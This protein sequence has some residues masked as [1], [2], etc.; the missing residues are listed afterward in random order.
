ME[1]GIYGY[2]RSS[3]K[4]DVSGTTLPSK[5]ISLPS[6]K[7]QLN[8]PTGKAGQTPIVIISRESWS[9]G[10]FTLNGVQKD[11]NSVT[12]APKGMCVGQHVLAAQE[13]TV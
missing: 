12:S 2:I 8:T 3:N 5:K 1:Y 6:G 4:D 11:G 10:Y 7:M 13:R 9:S